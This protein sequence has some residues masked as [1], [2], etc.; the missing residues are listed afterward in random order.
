MPY[1]FYDCKVT[2]IVDETP[3]VKRYTIQYPDTIPFQ[4]KAGQFVMLDL[5]ISTKH[6]TR[7]YSIASPPTSDNKI[8]LCIVLKPDGAGTNYL[9]KETKE[10]SVIKASVA[11]GKFTLPETI[12][13]DICFICTGTGIAPFRSMI[14]DIFNHKIPHKNI[15]LIFGNRFEKDILY[16]KELEELAS[17]EPSLTFIPVLSREDPG[18]WKG[19]KGY[20]HDVYEN[21][22]NGN[23]DTLFYICGWSAMLKEAR[24]RL[25]NKGYLRQQIRFES[26]E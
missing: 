6:T 14:L 17:R 3:V 8:E 20:V 7:S 25:E 2:D 11:I 12:D 26:F 13:Q 1:I 16:R 5:P 19:A 24:Q 9:F 10:G 23:K 18:N 21:L 15:Y 22:L 4:F